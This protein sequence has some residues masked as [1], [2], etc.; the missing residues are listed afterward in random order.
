[1]DESIPG[2]KL[3]KAWVATQRTLLTNWIDTLGGATPGAPGMGV[4]QQTVESWQSSVKQTLDAQATWMRDWT[5]SLA[6]FQGTPDELRDRA[7]QGQEVMRRWTEAQQQLWQ[8]WFEMARNFAPGVSTGAGTGAQAGQHVVELWTDT[9]R[10]L[11][12]TQAE[13]VQRFTTGLG[14]KSDG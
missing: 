12:E 13:W 4:W 14:G 2:E 3:V 8:G 10:K 11:M 9:A 5:E 6:T 7:R 1:M